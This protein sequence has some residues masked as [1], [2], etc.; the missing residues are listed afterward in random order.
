MVGEKFLELKQSRQEEIRNAFLYAFSVNDYNKFPLDEI[1][2]KINLSKEEFELF[3]ENKFEL[4]KYLLNYVFVIRSSITEEVKRENYE[5]F[6]DWWLATSESSI[7][8][9]QEYPLLGNF[10]YKFA[11]QVGSPQVEKLKDKAYDYS[12]RE[13][14]SLFNHE[15]EIGKFRRDLDITKLAHQF[16]GLRNSIPNYFFKINNIRPQRRVAQ[17]QS[18]FEDA[19]AITLRQAFKDVADLMR[20]YVVDI[21]NNNT[22]NHIDT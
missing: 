22:R 14:E 2:Y 20:F 5:N 3:F 16:V 4:Y 8:L 17:K 9:S 21:A 13:F 15:V 7:I 11:T 19:N 18:I 12:V 10:S 1:L 6:W